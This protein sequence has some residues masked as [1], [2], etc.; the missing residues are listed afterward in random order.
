[1]RKLAVALGVGIAVAAVFATAAEWKSGE[2]PPTLAERAAKN[3]RVLTKAQSRRL[4]EYAESVHRCVVGD[5]AKVAPP[6]A[7]RTRITMSAPGLSA[8][9]LVGFLE[10]CDPTVGPPPPKSS[11]QARTG[12][13]LVYLPKQCLL[14][15]TEVDEAHT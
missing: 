12:R 11:L 1:M 7:S 10:A 13:L 5:G 8:D 2:T 9:A 6:V 15:P 3:Y 14:D 4:V